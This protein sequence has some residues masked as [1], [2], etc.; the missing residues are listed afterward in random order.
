MKTAVYIMQPL[1][2]PT[3]TTTDDIIMRSKNVRHV[4]G[5]RLMRHIS[6]VTEKGRNVVKVHVKSSWKG[7]LI[8]EVSPHHDP[9][10]LAGAV[11]DRDQINPDPIKWLYEAPTIERHRIS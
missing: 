10:A 8:A 7:V 4:Q 9:L 2:T 6:S 3:L 1:A 11:L 5:G